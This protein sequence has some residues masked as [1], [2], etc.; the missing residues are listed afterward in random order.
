[1][2][3]K[4][5]DDDYRYF[6]DT[7]LTPFHLDADFISDIQARLPELPD[8]KSKRYLSQYSLPYSDAMILADDPELA[9]FFDA[10]VSD[11]SPSHAK[12]V[13]NLLLNEVSAWLRQNAQSLSTVLFSPADLAELVTLSAEGTVSSKQVKELF[14][15]MAET[16]RSPLAI[17]DERGMRQVSDSA[18]IE[19]QI[20]A[21]MAANPDQVA[22][23]RG[24]KTGLLGFFVGQVMRNMHGQGNPQLISEILSE[25]LGEPGS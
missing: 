3:S 11:M 6:P 14:S 21:V 5:T 20:L 13:A 18:A 24:G 15:T 1:M 22:E 10:T 9:E 4:E 25:R 2:R 7:N 8:A 23:Y 17:V 12:R 16:G 19:E